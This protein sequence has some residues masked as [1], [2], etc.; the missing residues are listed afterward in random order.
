MINTHRQAKDF[1]NSLKSKLAS[2]GLFYPLHHCLEATAKA[3]GFD[4][5]QALTKAE[6]LPERPDKARFQT[7]LLAALP[8]ACRPSVNAWLSNEPLPQPI[9][10]YPPRWYLD[11]V[12]YFLATMALHRRTPLLRAG[13]GTGQ[14][15]RAKIIDHLL[16]DVAGQG[17]NAPLFDPI[18]FD[19]IFVGKVGEI[20]A[21]LSTNPNFTHERDRLVD[22]GILKLDPDS[23]RVAS[24]G[25]EAVKAHAIWSR[26]SKAKSFIEH[27]IEHAGE[28][29]YEALSLIGVRRARDIAEALLN[30]GDRRYIVASGSLREVL[31]Q[32][33][34]D[35]DLEV[36]VHALNV[37][38]LIIP[39]SARELRDAVPAKIL[40]EFVARNQKLPITGAFRWMADNPEWADSLR[41]TANHPSA[42][43]T[44]VDAMVAGIRAT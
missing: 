20:F 5:W 32:I 16:L 23:V 34:Q 41:A 35:G 6:H 29:V 21:A 13:S 36:F 30:Y 28:G 31:S 37:F 26:A 38:A 11:A 9:L 14:K 7:R 25:I 43:T 24:P 42:F 8:F 12:P 1:A 3:V 44:T 17:M 39:S 10:G 4:R 40:N 2:S 18:T 27:D 15:L 33:A 19:F 22:A